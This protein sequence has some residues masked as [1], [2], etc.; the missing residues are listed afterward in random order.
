MSSGNMKKIIPILFCAFLLLV[1]GCS[2]IDQDMSGCEAGVPVLVNFTYALNA[3]DTEKIFSE[4]TR[5][6]LY[7]FS[8]NGVLAGYWR[9]EGREFTDRMT[10]SLTPG[11]YRFVAWGGE[12]TCRYY[13][14]PKRIVGQSSLGQMRLSLNRTTGNQLSSKPYNLYYGSHEVT[15][16]KNG[17]NDLLI[18][19]MRNTNDIKVIVH[20][21][22]TQ[23]PVPP[24]PGDDTALDRYQITI[25]G[26]NACHKFDNNFDVASA[27]DADILYIP[28]KR[29]ATY[30]D[31]E[32]EMRVMRLGRGI[33]T[34]GPGDNNLT[35]ELKD[36]RTGEVMGSYNLLDQIITKHPEIENNPDGLTI[37]EALDKYSE[38][39]INI[40]FT[41]TDIQL[42]IT[43][44]QTWE[45]RLI[46]GDME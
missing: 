31:L 44:A 21:L 25:A 34:R 37:D 7:A 19:L 23:L 17:D 18:A 11:R 2:A 32:T 22:D 33:A 29:T 3:D 39:T 30:R 6:D 13:N 27:A 26:D 15:E 12:E 40:Y 1:S 42:S 28:H 41:P 24:T 46:I 14:V 9:V 16:I 8:E 45:H 5:M 10:V 35:L 36:T 38:Y 4:V 43:V 20:G